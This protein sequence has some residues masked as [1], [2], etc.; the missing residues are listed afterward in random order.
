MHKLFFSL[1]ITGLSFLLLA[2]LILSLGLGAV[3]IS[4]LEVLKALGARLPWLRERVSTNSI[5]V[6]IIWDFRLARA[7]LA[8][9]VGAAL[10]VSGAAFQ[11]LFRNP[12]AD[13]FVIGA[14]SGAALGA[15][16]AII[17]KL[18]F[19]L[20]GFGPVQFA[21]FAGAVAAVV[22]V[23]LI[24]QTGGSAP[25]AVALLLAGTALSSLFAA[26][27]S[28][29]MALYT[30]DLN[31]IFF[32]LLG[33]FSG[34]SWP[35]LFSMLPYLFLSFIL[36]GILVRPLDIMAF[37]VE[38][39]RGMGLAVS[40]ARLLIVVAA[41]LATAAAVASSGIIGFIGL[42]APHAARMIFG[43]IHRRLIPASALLG[44]IL[45]VAADDLARTILAPVELPVGVLTALL[46][47]PFFLY[48]LRVR[49]KS[50]GGD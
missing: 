30:K 6:T 7:L 20:G 14:S 25:P 17:F 11:G 9:A 19:S 45:L 29:L 46:G 31:Q 10:A 32:W 28:L 26:A 49:Q 16:I 50:L 35:H 43:P 15:T 41:S 24:S 37:G 13:P 40:R 42:L 39:A 4:R 5:T 22:L 27:V 23:Y 12:L 33:S 18:N 48:L 44:A 21:A 3:P 1:L 38:T 8:A 34:K 47:A 2:V 36:A